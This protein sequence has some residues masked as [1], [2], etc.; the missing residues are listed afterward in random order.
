MKGQEKLSKAELE[1]YRG[2][3]SGKSA[4]KYLRYFC[5]IHGSDNQRSLQVNPDNGH[6]RCYS[7]GAWGYLEE[8]RRSDLQSRPEKQR[9]DGQRKFSL[10]IKEAAHPGYI[11]S[12]KQV[13]ENSHKPELMVSVKAYQDYLPNS[14][15]EEYLKRRG[16]SH[17]TAG[18]Y[19][20]GYSPFG[21]WLHKGRDWKFGRLVFPHTNSDGG[22]VNL[23][24]R[25]VGSDNKV[26]REVRHDHLP[27]AKGVFNGKAL[28]SDTVFICE[29]VFDALSLISAGY[30][31]AC[32]IFG[33]YGIRWEWIKSRRIVF[34]LDNDSAGSESRSSLCWEGSVRGKDVYFLSEK[35]YGGYKDLNELWV[36]EGGIDVGEW[37]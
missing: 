6:F 9:N 35:T 13:E 19:N 30:E 32:A 25:A 20:V 1:F 33:I 3:G 34:C 21:N 22:I 37:E 8:Y 26:P 14:W 17:E 11:V 10:K 28:L 27:G 23:Y 24:G 4:G 36:G 12:N 29:G 5:P 16:I 18:R 31:N 7:C 2:Q 15:G